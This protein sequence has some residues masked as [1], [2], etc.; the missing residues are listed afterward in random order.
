M[1][2]PGN[3]DLRRAP[4]KF[5]DCLFQI[6]PMNRY[7]AQTQYRKAQEKD[8]TSISDVVFHKQ[9]HHAAELEKR[10]N[11]QESAKIMGTEL[12]Y[13]SVVQLLHIKSNKFLTVNKR[14]AGL[15]ERNAMRVTL[16]EVGNEGSWFY[17]QPHYKHRNTND[18]VIIGDKLI[19]K[20]VGPG[21]PLHASDFSVR[22][23]CA[24]YSHPLTI[25]SACG[26]F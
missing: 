9:L 23:I 3:G 24:Y 11:E 4:K 2:R 1:V 10:Q 22:S 19:L 26:P 15:M 8:A 7:L 16:E 21:Q 25:P 12:M 14:L 13:G 18:N 6:C 5:R 20:S 17:I